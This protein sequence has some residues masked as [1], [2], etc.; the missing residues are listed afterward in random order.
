M[1]RR[2]RSLVSRIVKELI[3]QHGLRLL[4]NSYYEIDAARRR[5]ILLLKDQ[6]AFCAEL[7][8]GAIGKLYELAR[9][10]TT[11]LKPEN[12]GRVISTGVAGK[13]PIPRTTMAE[14]A[15]PGE[16]ID[17]DDCGQV[18]LEELAAVVLAAAIWDKILLTMETRPMMRVHLDGLLA[19]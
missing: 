5:Y 8:D 6:P 17:G 18:I 11:H 4:Q 9:E 12:L 3:S 2:D 7:A 15:N 1:R 10:K 16:M 13:Q 14:V 19:A